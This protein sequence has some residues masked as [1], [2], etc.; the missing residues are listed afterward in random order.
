MPSFQFLV[1]LA[2]LLPH[3]IYPE[4]KRKPTLF[5]LALHHLSENLHIIDSKVSFRFR[6]SARFFLLYFSFCFLFYFFN[7]RYQL[8]IPALALMRQPVWRLNFRW[9]FRK[10]FN[11]FDPWKPFWYLTEYLK[12]F[13]DT[14]RFLILGMYL[15]VRF[16]QVGTIHQT[17]RVRVVF[18]ACKRTHCRRHL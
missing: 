18:W 15:R 9:N 11:E 7:R 3:Y 5:M 14:F 8:N 12:L 6:L 17:G 1:S 10:G 16:V 4:I 2:F 13:T